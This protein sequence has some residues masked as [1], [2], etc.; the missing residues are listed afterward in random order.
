MTFTSDTTN[1]ADNAFDS[2]TLL[3]SVTIPTSVTVIGAQAFESCTALTSVTIPS[4][5]TTISTQAFYGC[6]SLTSVT[7]PTSVT[8]IGINTYILL[9]LLIL[10][11]TIGYDAFKNCPFTCI[12]LWNPTT[13]RSVGLDALPT[14]TI[15]PCTDGTYLVD[16]VCSTYSPTPSPT[17]SPQYTT[18]LAVSISAPI[19]MIIIIVIVILRLLKRR[20]RK[21]SLVH[22]PKYVIPVKT[23][24]SDNKSEISKFDSPTQYFVLGGVEDYQVLLLSSSYHHYPY[25]YDYY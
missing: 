25:C 11:L 21:K 1:I 17:L 20:R 24:V 8:T 7:I 9:L 13:T 22:V 12:Y 6:S 14:T 4:S 23:D 19:V 2:C 15:C 16:Y 18:Y 10:I 5:V 3:T